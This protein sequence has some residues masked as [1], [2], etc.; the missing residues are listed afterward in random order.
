VKH[1]IL[2]QPSYSAAKVW[3]DMGE[4]IVAEAGAMVSMSPTI[5][6]DSK[7]ASGGV[8]GA[9]K[10][11]LGGESLFR[12]TF[13]AATGPGEVLLAPAS[14]GDVMALP[15]E[16]GK[17]YVQ[18]GSYLA[19]TPGL[20]TSVEA[21]ARS[22]FSGEGLFLL[23]V[24]GAGDLFLSSFGAIHRVTLAPG[25]E[26]IADTA[27]MVAFDGTI[28]YKIEKAAGGTG[29]LGN[30]VKGL[31]KSALSG[32]GLVCRYRGPG[33]VYLQT[34]S[35]QGFIRLLAPLLNNKGE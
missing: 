6:I 34:R 9:V 18:G 25:E 35:F 7:M 30:L 15:M 24:A 1:E 32:E 26:Y 3:L 13:T 27:H 8:F 20:E 19:S 12:T 31:V 28:T 29:G 22:M 11:A 5:S 17:M 14:T 2:Y 4:S 33:N 23:T 16:G 21:S 10:S